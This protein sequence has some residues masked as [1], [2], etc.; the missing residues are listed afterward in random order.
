M[1]EHRAGKTGFCL[2]GSGKASRYS[3]FRFKKQVCRYLGG[4]SKVSRIY[5]PQ[6]LKER[7]EM[8]TFKYLN[9]VFKEN[10]HLRAICAS[11]HFK[12]SCSWGSSTWNHSFTPSL[13]LNISGSFQSTWNKIPI[14]CHGWWGHVQ[15]GL[16]LAKDGH[17]LLHLLPLSSL[18]F[19]ATLVGSPFFTKPY[20]CL[21]N[22]LAFVVSSTW[23]FA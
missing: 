2:K 6:N 3:C 23:L 13:D 16:D 8:T 12:S 14:D 17:S 11:F 15:I 10:Q 9:V 18:L 22:A 5:H 4:C 7:G 1:Q 21:L 20:L 19:W